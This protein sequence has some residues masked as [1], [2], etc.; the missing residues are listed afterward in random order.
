MKHAHENPTTFKSKQNKARV[1]LAFGD[2]KNMGAW[3]KISSVY[4]QQLK[5]F[6]EIPEDKIN[7]WVR[8]LHEISV[9]YYHEVGTAMH[10][11]LREITSQEINETTLVELNESKNNLFLAMK[12]AKRNAIRNFNNAKRDKTVRKLQKEIA[13]FQK[14][15]DENSSP[16]G[17]EDPILHKK[18]NRLERLQ[19]QLERMQGRQNSRSQS[20]EESQ[21]EKDDFPGLDET[22]EEKGGNDYPPAGPQAGGSQA[23]QYRMDLWGDRRQRTQARVSD[24]SLKYL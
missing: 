21:A 2:V 24:L 13:Y 9:A 23:G 16:E 5:T 12:E 1:E 6:N 20:G 7:N 18:Q 14:Q 22:D 4:Q 19:K 3:S 15:V 17:N 11:F 8:L 10:G